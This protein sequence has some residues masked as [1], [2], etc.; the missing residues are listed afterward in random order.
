MILDRLEVYIA[1]LA[2]LGILIGGFVIGQELVV[3]LRNVFVV[4][5]VFYLVGLII[6]IYLRAKVFPLPTEEDLDSLGVFEFDDLLDEDLTEGMIEFSQEGAETGE[7]PGAS[8]GLGVP[9][10]RPNAL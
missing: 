1:L 6:R 9:D 8:L 2:G 7:V 4:M 3:V 5:L 10:D